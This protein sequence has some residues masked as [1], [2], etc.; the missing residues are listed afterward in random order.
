M[1]YA[2]IRDNAIIEYRDY[3][4][5]PECKLVAGKPMLRPVS[6]APRPSVDP[7][8]YSVKPSRT[9]FDDRVE[10]GWTV[11]P[12]SLDV[13]KSIQRRRIND[14]RDA[15]EDAGFDYLGKR[16]DSN[17][18]AIKRLY[19]AALA[20]QSALSAGAIPGDHFVDWTCADGSVKPLTYAEAAG[21]VVAMAPIGAALHGKAKALKAQIDAAASVAE[22]EAVKW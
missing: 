11:T 17:A 9:I 1:E 5:P 8:L 2:L 10:A 19:G 18:Q 14:A 20:A 16:F 3:P 22:V 15:E 12:V 7:E 4:S 21:L 13:A 6:H